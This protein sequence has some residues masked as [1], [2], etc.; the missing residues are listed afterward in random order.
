MQL[1]ETVTADPMSFFRSKTAEEMG[2]I[3][4]G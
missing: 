1:I 2:R 4:L 3:V